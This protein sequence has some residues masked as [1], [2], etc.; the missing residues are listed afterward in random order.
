MVSMFG[1][2]RPVPA[3]NAG[4][5]TGGRRLG[6]IDVLRGLAALAVVFVH[7][8]RVMLVPG[9]A[10]GL[11]FLPSYLGSRG[12]ILFL[13][14]SGFCIHL[15]VAEGLAQGKGVSWKWTAFW[16]RRFVRLYPPYLGAIVFS[17]VLS[18]F[19]VYPPWTIYGRGKTSLAADLGSHLLMIH[20]L[21]PAY[22]FGL[23]N[24]VFWTL[25]LEEQLYLLYAV[26]LL[27]RWLL[28]VR[29][30]YAIPGAV[31]CAWFVATEVTRVLFHWTP[32]QSVAW[33]AGWPFGL[34]FVWLLGALAA[35]VQA[36][37]LT[38]P[39]WCYQLWVALL[40]LGLGVFLDGAVLT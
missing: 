27:L 4:P 39:R 35:E 10:T 31:A 23:Y 5:G 30:A 19:F 17:L 9:H 11:L 15:R 22:A 7:I 26:F 32:L 3:A 6:S 21:L 1:Q 16:R 8:P 40:F 12:V 14:L 36:G 37:A 33:A 20:N 24:P 38:L 28:P 29:L 13:V 34:W 2:Y 18:C 25:G